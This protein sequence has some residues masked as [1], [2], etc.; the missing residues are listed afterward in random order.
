MSKIIKV[1]KGFNINLAGK[2]EKV[3]ANS[4]QPETFAV[5]PIDFLG[6][7]RPKVLVNVGDNIKAGTPI[8]LDKK[9]ER[10]LYTAPVSGEVVEIRRGEKR[11]LLEI[12]ILADK[13]IEFVDFKK[14]NSS[15]ITSLNKDTV[16]EIIL[17]G[18][19]WPYIIQRPFGIIANPDDVPKSIFISGF[20]THPLAPDYHFMF[21]GDV[22]SFQAGI[23]ILRKLTSGQVHLSTNA[24][25]EVSPIFAQA[26]GVEN[27]E[28]RGPHPAGNVGIQIHHI[29]PIN[30][31]DIVWTVQ[32]FGVILIGRLFLEG[33]YNTSKLLAVAGSEVKKPQYFKTYIGACINRFADNNILEENV[34]Y[35]SGNVLTGKKIS[36]DGFVGF[37]DHLVT[38]IPEGDYYELFGWIKPTTKRLSFHRAVGLFSFLNP[39][40]EYA[41]DT[42]TRGEERPFVQSGVFEKVLPMDI[43][44]V[45]LLKSIL[46]EDYDGMEAL[47]IYEVIE[48]DMALCEFVDVSKHNVQEILREGLDLIKDS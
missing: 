48:E 9:N 36:K 10:I 3:I 40:K 17:S 29:D 25:A 4:P 20:D 7:K 46:A 30:K 5:K 11:K 44:P 14:H 26:K 24:D 47:G 19:V 22:A 42:N 32:P 43:L 8:L 38:V 1:K 41:L 37:Y 6:I 18:G 28:F 45:H 34:R 23:D 2:A 33:R 35:I 39:N 21:K 27:H 16:K 13:T 12:V 31:G 15:E